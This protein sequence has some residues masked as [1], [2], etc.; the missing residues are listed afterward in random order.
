MPESTLACCA[1]TTVNTLSYGNAEK[2]I[3]AV[4]ADAAAKTRFSRGFET[5]D[6]ASS[7]SAAQPRAAGNADKA[8]FP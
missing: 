3:L 5:D 6:Q 1:A 8:A 4:S 2:A 7:I